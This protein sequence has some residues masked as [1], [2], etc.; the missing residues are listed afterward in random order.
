MLRENRCQVCGA[1][2]ELSDAIRKRERDFERLDRC[3][4]CSTR[5]GDKYRPFERKIRRER[6]LALTVCIASCVVA[7]LVVTTSHSEICRS[8]PVIERLADRA[9]VQ[10]S[11]LTASAV[12]LSSLQSNIALNLPDQHRLAKAIQKNGLFYVMY[13]NEYL[14]AGGLPPVRLS[15][16]GRWLLLR[17]GA[18][19]LGL[20]PAFERPS[21]TA[22]FNSEACQLQEET[23]LLTVAWSPD[24]Q[25]TALMAEVNG[26]RRVKLVTFNAQRPEEIRISTCADAY[27]DHVREVAWLDNAHLF[28]LI[29]ENGDKR[30]E[31]RAADDGRLILSS[32]LRVSGVLNDLHIS[33]SGHYA[34]FT[35]E[36]VYG[37]RQIYWLD[38]SAQPVLYTLGIAQYNALAGS[39]FSWVNGH[40]VAYLR[41]DWQLVL[42]D[43]DK[44]QISSGNVPPE[45]TQ[46]D[47]FVWI[48][49]LQ[50]SEQ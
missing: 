21:T 3:V 16:S 20:Y 39:F 1:P 19:Q 45:I 31:V 15:T 42:L 34:L 35:A 9:C 37:A 33:P 6:V 13:N 41:H 18:Q 29:D 28:Y 11:D 32:T 10:P 4:F 25:R 40:Q 7:F 50:N 22:K 30:F 5:F 12:S 17:H 26:T 47:R 23:P 24:E 36:D 48:T 38:L 49:W 43:L 44:R 27:S 2:K 14:Y 8:K 46:G